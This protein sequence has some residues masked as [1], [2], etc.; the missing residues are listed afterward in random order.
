MD[1]TLIDVGHISGVQIGDEVVLIGSQGEEQISVEEVSR[2]ANRIPYEL[3]CSITQRV[4]R[5]YH[6]AQKQIQPYAVA[7]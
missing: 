4:P 6:P 1:Q 7:Q 5:L 2:W 3:L